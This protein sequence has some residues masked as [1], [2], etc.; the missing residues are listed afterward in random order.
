MNLPEDPL[1]KTDSLVD[2]AEL[3]DLDSPKSI[4]SDL[5]EESVQE[6]KPASKKRAFS[7]IERLVTKLTDSHYFIN[8]ILACLFANSIYLFY[9]DFDEHHRFSSLLMMIQMCCVT[10]FF[11]IRVAPS[12]V[13]MAPLDWAA[14]I[15]G[16]LLPMLISPVGAADEIVPLMLTQFFGIF[17]SIVAII[18]LNTSFA[19]IPALRNIKTGGLYSLIRHPIYFSYFLTF[20]CVVLQNF[21]LRNVVV[22]L[23]LYCV[24][25]YRIIAEERV[26]SEDQDYIYYK[27][28]VRYRI[29]P[30]LW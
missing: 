4:E 6:K 29:I 28:R 16:T 10:L 25:I 11:L 9:V 3:T 22:L 7:E 13:S 18:S 1:Q 20:T 26:L 17:I 2:S 27:S 5:I 15:I 23:A 19:V 21:S 24:D 14:A 30:F 8:L 12:K